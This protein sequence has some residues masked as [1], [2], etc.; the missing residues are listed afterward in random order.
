MIRFQ[1][2]AHKTFTDGV[3]GASPRAFTDRALEPYAPERRS[4]SQ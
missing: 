2:T 1:D 4:Q 3:A